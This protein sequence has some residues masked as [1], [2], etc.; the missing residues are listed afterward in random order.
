VPAG[1]GDFE[2]AL[3][4]LLA[5]DVGK[6]ERHAVDFADFR[7]RPREHLRAAKMVGQ[8]NE[9]L[10]GDDFDLG[11]G[12]GRLRTTKLWTNQTLPARIGADGGGQNAGDRR[13]R[14][15]EAEFAQN[16]EA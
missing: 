12:P 5:F 3:G 16:G 6:V 10:R 1:G 11:A 8:L 14:T 9:R 4:A 15:V 2:R 13:N 7:L